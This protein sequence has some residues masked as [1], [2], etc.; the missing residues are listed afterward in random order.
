MHSF[1]LYESKIFTVT[2]FFIFSVRAPAEQ[3]VQN[4]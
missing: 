1:P 4:I 2:E 3:L